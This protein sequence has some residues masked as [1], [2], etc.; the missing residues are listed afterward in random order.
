MKFG[1]ADYS[2]EE[3]IKKVIDCLTEKEKLTR[4]EIKE[5]HS[6]GTYPISLHT[7]DNYKKSISSTANTGVGSMKLDTFYDICAYTGVSADYFLGFSVAKHREQSAEMVKKEFGL[8]DKAIGM[9]LASKLVEPEYKGEVSS[10]VIDFILKNS[11][12]WS[13]LDDFLPIYMAYKYDHNAPV[14]D[15]GMV[16]Y[17]LLSIFEGLINEVCDSIYKSSSQKTL[18]HVNI[19]QPLHG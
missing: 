8:S 17:T 6:K 15:I 13:K 19:K 7:W 2:S 3:I 4:D 14:L 12:F 16:K 11:D 1:F 5:K 10:E 18:P 9:L